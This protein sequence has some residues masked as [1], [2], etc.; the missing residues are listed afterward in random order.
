MTVRE[1][2]NDSTEDMGFFL[3]N[4]IGDK[5]ADASELPKMLDKIGYLDKKDELIGKTTEC[6][7]LD[8]EECA[9]IGSAEKNE[10]I[11]ISCRTNYI[12]QTF[13]DS[14]YI[15]RI[16]GRVNAV[17]SIP[18]NLFAGVESFDPDDYRKYAGSIAFTSLDYSCV[19]CDTIS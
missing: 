10:C 5:L 14:D 18:N 12:L 17:V 3:L 13:I 16:S 8:A 1:L 11:E 2:L 7:L 6:E 19:E 9:I 4:C 15:W